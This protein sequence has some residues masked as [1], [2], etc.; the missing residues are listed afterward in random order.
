MP[1]TVHVYPKA[2]IEGSTWTYV[3]KVGASRFVHSEA[4]GVTAEIPLTLLKLSYDL[5][6]PDGVS[7]Q[8][9]DDAHWL[10]TASGGP[11]NG[12]TLWGAWRDIAESNLSGLS[13]GYTKADYYAAWSNQD[14]SRVRD[15][16]RRILVNGLG[17]SIDVGSIHQ[18]EGDGTNTDG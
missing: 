4:A 12:K 3:V 16:G 14:T 6:V 9:I 18:H 5:T 7:D 13:P 10:A 17:W 1:R 8:D 2:T 11:N 15:Q